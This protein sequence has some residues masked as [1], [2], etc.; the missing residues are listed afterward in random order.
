MARATIQVCQDFTQGDDFRI[1][2]SHNPVVDITG[3]QF[4]LTLKKNETGNPV[5]NV[6]YNV[7]DDTDDD[8]ANGIAYVN[9]PASATSLVEPGEY[10]ASLKRILNGDTVTLVRTGM[11]DARKV[12]VFK[13]LTNY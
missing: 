8:A 3:G 6:L 1:K 12:K 13:N 4:R 11:N 7:G 9:I 2:V 5:L 10:Y